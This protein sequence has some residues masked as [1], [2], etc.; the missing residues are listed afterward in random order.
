MLGFLELIGEGDE[1]L[2]KGI[3]DKQPER[4]GEKT[5]GVLEAK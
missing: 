3:R 1:Q 4:V 2:P 5:N